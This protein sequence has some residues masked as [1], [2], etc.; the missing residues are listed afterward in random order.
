[1]IHEGVYSL[2]NWMFGISNTY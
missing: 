2:E 1:V